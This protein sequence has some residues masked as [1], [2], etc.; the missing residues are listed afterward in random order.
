MIIKRQVM[1]LKLNAIFAG[2]IGVAVTAAGY[3]FNPNEL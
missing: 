3:L 1:K 2:I